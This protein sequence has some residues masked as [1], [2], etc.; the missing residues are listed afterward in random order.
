MQHRNQI[1]LIAKGVIAVISGSAL[2]HIVT[3][4][5]LYGSDWL[6]PDRSM[7]LFEDRECKHFYEP[8]PLCLA[9]VYGVP[10]SIIALVTWILLTPKGKSNQDY[11]HCARCGYDLFGNTSGVCPECGTP[12]KREIREDW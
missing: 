6:P 9:A 4:S 1:R 5:V 12:T 11:R 2:S 8:S 3:W 10:C 7:I